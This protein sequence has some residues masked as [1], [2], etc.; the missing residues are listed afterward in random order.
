MAEPQNYT[1]EKKVDR[2]L[3]WKLV[4]QN[5]GFNNQSCLNLKNASFL[6]L[7]SFCRAG[8]AI[9][10]YGLKQIR[11]SKHFSINFSEGMICEKLLTKV[12]RKVITNIFIQFVK[13][14]FWY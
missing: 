12:L 2:K 9:Q 1:T 11:T 6:I 3:V 8:I 7:V 5:K 4:L 10:E 13:I 14:L